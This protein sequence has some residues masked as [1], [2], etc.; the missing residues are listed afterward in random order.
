[1]AT[2]PDPESFEAQVSLRVRVARRRAGM[3]QEEVAEALRIPT[4]TYRNKE[5]CRSHFKAGQ[6][7]AIEG[8]LGVVRCDLFNIGGPIRFHSRRISDV[9][10]SE[11]SD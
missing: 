4:T 11:V 2:P 5:R 1:M 6:T 10:A 9:P 7:L 8:I 3:T